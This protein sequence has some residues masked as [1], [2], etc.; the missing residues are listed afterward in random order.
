L[1]DTRLDIWNTTLRDI[2]DILLSFAPPQSWTS[3]YYISDVYDRTLENL[4]GDIDFLTIN[5]GFL[6]NN[7]QE[8]EDLTLQTADLLRHWYLMESAPSLMALCL[9]ALDR[10]QI[11]VDSDM[12]QAIAIACVLGEVPNELPYHSILHYKKVVLQM[13][14]LINVH[15]GVYK[16]TDY[17]CDDQDIAFLLMAAAIHD[18]GHDGKGNTIKGVYHQARLER[19][20]YFILV[21]Y[22]NAIGFKDQKRYQRM[23]DHLRITL[24]CTDT[25]PMGDPASFVNQMKAAYRVHFLNQK[26]LSYAGLNLDP[27]VKELEY[28]A[29][30]AVMALLLHEA[31]MA[32]SSGLTYEVTVFETALFYKE[33][34]QPEAKPSSIIEFINTIC[35]RQVLSSAGQQL[36]STNMARIMVLANKGIED[37]DA[38]FPDPEHA[39]F[40]LTHDT[41][42]ADDSSDR[43]IN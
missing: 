12:R 6:F 40:L 5:A 37:G 20:S 33:I 30:L 8:T 1:D 7:T 15:N 27:E 2:K 16:G 24:L 32:T 18:L 11:E 17:V 23:M 39:T 36:Y 22:F 34:K 25:S 10:F 19:N 28:N 3:K 9:F 14:R 35:E 38:A 13:I 4:K 21:K 29:K 31:D 26:V 41:I 42:A 43:T